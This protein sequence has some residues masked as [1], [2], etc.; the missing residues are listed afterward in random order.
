MLI[1]GEFIWKRSFPEVAGTQIGETTLT[2]NTME[3]K[4]RRQL[5]EAFIGKR[6]IMGN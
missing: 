1:P 3:M 2:V 4:A 6:D 5:R